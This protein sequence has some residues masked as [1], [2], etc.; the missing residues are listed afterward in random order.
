MRD[1]WKVHEKKLMIVSHSIY[2]PVVAYKKEILIAEMPGY[3]QERDFYS[4]YCGS[5]V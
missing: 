3:G 5:G 1:C 4:T 2:L